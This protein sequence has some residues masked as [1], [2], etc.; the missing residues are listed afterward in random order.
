MEQSK[1]ER[2]Q[3]FLTIM[4]TIHD[5]CDVHRLQDTLK[6]RKPKLY[7]ERI[8]QTLASHFINATGIEQNVLSADMKMF[9]LYKEIYTNEDGLFVPSN[10]EDTVCEIVI[11]V[12]DSNSNIVRKEYNN[13]NCGAELYL[14][15]R[16]DLHAHFI[17][18]VLDKNTLDKNTLDRNTFDNNIFCVSPDK[19]RSI[20]S[21]P[22]NTNIEGLQTIYMGSFEEYEQQ[23][24]K[25]KVHTY[26]TRPM[27]DFVTV[28]SA[29]DYASDCVIRRNLQ[30]YELS[31]SN[32]EL[33]FFDT[34]GV[35]K[36]GGQYVIYHN[37]GDK[38][39]LIEMDKMPID[40]KK[41]LPLFAL[42]VLDALDKSKR[43]PFD[44]D[45]IQDISLIQDIAS[46][47]ISLVFKIGCPL[48]TSSGKVASIQLSEDKYI[49][50]LYDLKRAM[51]YL[52]IK[53][54]SEANKH[55]TTS[56]QT[57]F[58][59][60]SQDRLAVMYSLLQGCPTLHTKKDKRC[61]MYN[62]PIIGG[63]IVDKPQKRSVNS[64]Q[65]SISTDVE[66][67][68]TFYNIPFNDYIDASNITLFD[69]FIAVLKEQSKD[70]YLNL[71]WYVTYKKLFY[72]TMPT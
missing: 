22:I 67:R 51:D 29:G 24:S 34:L 49:Q 14:N 42:S 59:Y 16:Q 72:L 58:V 17:K 19:V 13:L 15:L 23:T 60:V 64:L 40:A 11:G 63:G 50:A 32:K 27:T 54:C 1:K 5:F 25:R 28:Q 61:V 2:L 48:M 21:S 39:Y 38:E 3:Y 44:S 65:N 37:I 56:H 26:I 41:G 69:Q 70:K 71:V 8:L 31:K 10:F 53:A 52:P 46:K 57:K 36:S 20:T 35:K 30:N 55:P 33:L 66:Q 43:K 12:L 18:Y 7:R 62:A 9:S 6:Q 68:D 47:T 45:P 4:D